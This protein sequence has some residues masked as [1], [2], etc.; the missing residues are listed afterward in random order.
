M[1]GAEQMLLEN[2][3]ERIRMNIHKQFPDITFPEPVMEPV[4]YGRLKH[5]AFPNRK[6][7]LDLNTGKE[8]DIVSNEYHLITHEE[9]V[10]DLLSSVPEEFGAPKVSIKMWADSA[11]IR[12][13]LTFPDVPGKE[14]FEIK[15]GDMVEPR[16]S[17]YSSYDRS[18]YQGVAF[19]ALQ[20][21]CTNGLVA[22]REEKK[23]R[24][25]ILSS[26]VRPEELTNDV[27]QFLTDFS[28][29]TD[30]WREWANR[31][32]AKLEFDEVMTALPFSEAETTR[33]KE[34][35]LMNNDG[36]NILQL[37]KITLWDVSSA[38]TQFARHEV[39]GEQRSMELEGQIAAVLYEV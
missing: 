6:A 1:T 10:H 33:I 20:Q 8:W 29:T 32:L 23:R 18:T 4:W 9:V 31:T 16:I 37:D 2:E 35:P 24:K 27:K 36:K 17:A 26:R 25:H 14:R 38:A 28:S 21:V 39:R 30:L 7:I 13:S 15:A 22:F 19:G 11:R 12:V 34:L 5:K 3:I